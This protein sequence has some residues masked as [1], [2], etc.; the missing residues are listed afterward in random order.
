MQDLFV[1]LHEEISHLRLGFVVGG[2]RYQKT[3]FPVVSGKRCRAKR[4]KIF[5]LSS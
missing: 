4:F 5:A 1:N 3:P 2:L